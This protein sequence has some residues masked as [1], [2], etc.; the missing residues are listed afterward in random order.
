MYV[1]IWFSQIHRLRLNPN[2]KVLNT[3]VVSSVVVKRLSSF[4]LNLV[5]AGRPLQHL[6]VL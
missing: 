5:Y 2:S 6:A 1:H 3:M 4:L